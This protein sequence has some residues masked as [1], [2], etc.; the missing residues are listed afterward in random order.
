MFSGIIEQLATVEKIIPSGSGL[1]FVF[2]ANIVNELKIDQSVAHN[3]VC[4]TVCHISENKYHVV[5]IKETLDK[6]NL[7][8]LKVGDKA[9]LERCIRLSDRLDGHIVQGHVDGTATVQQIEDVDGSWFFS[10][11]LN[12]DF[13]TIDGV[14]PQKLMIQKGSITING[15]SLTL[16]SAKDKH[17][18]VAII[19]YTYEH[20]NFHTLKIGDTVN[21]EL[22]ILG[23]YL[24]KLNG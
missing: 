19:P 4:L 6:T 2:S 23:K 24:A 18:K 17:F 13:T 12:P 9:N 3:G 16:V 1:E 21:I 8:K 15:T 10:F 22:D 14:E 7:G 20:T 11:V 5:A